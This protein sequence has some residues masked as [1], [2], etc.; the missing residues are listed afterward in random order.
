MSG[1]PSVQLLGSTKLLSDLSEIREEI[2]WVLDDKFAEERSLPDPYQDES[3]ILNS[4]ILRDY[5]IS[6]AWVQAKLIKTGFNTRKTTQKGVR[7]MRESLNKS[8]FMQSS[9]VVIYP[10]SDDDDQDESENP[11]RL[12]PED[13]KKGIRFLCADGMHRC[14]AVAEMAE[15]KANGDQ[16]IKCG[17]MV[18]AIILR[19]DTPRKYLIKLSLS[20]FYFH[21]GIYKYFKK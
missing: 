4:T 6:T 14:R 7:R 16:S 8:G 12:T 20:K 17:D 13:T 18:Y 11:F 9:A 21:F 5:T 19:P 2:D 15:K 1:L 10:G 3:K